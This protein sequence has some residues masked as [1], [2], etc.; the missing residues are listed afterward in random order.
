MKLKASPRFDRLGAFIVDYVLYMTVISIF[1][2]LMYFIDQRDLS[3]NVTLAGFSSTMRILVNIT[4]ILI[5]L[6]LTVFV[7][8]KIFPGQSIGKKVMQLKVVT[9]NQGVAKWYHYLAREIFG[10]L[11]LEGTT[12]VYMVSNLT[13]DLMA[14]LLNLDQ[15]MIQQWQ[16]IATFIFIFSVLLAALTPQRRMF[17][18]YLAQ[19]QVIT[20]KE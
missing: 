2:I 12:L 11:T 17:K 1:M 5:Y 3:G 4:G 8:T 20:I 19:T 9:S 10:A 16:T 7:P 14:I 6:G 13:R 15:Q 18:D